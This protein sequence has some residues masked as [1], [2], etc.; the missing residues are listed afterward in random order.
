LLRATSGD[1]TPIHVVEIK[2]TPAEAASPEA[3]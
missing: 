1:D 2:T 3:A